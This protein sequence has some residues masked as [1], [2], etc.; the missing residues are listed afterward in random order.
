MKQQSFDALL[1][2]FGDM[3]PTSISS[4]PFEPGVGLKTIHDPT[5]ESAG[6]E[7]GRA[8]TELATVFVRPL[9]PY[10]C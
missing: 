9:Y 7:V 8:L 5:L 1:L 4:R 3:S 10:R 6:A 2:E